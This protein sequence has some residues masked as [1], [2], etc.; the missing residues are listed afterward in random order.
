MCTEES[1]ECPANQEVSNCFN[2]TG[3]DTDALPDGE[4]VGHNFPH[5]RGCNCFNLRTGKVGNVKDK[6]MLALTGSVMFVPPSHYLHVALPSHW[7]YG[8]H[9]S[10]HELMWLSPQDIHVSQRNIMLPPPF[11]HSVP[12]QSYVPVREYICTLIITKFITVA[13][14]FGTKSIPKLLSVFVH[15]KID[16]CV[17]WF[18]SFISR[19]YHR[20]GILFAVNGSSV[21]KCWFQYYHI[22]THMTHSA[23]V[24]TLATS[25]LALDLSLL[26]QGLK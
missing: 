6:G 12:S 18:T 21:V 17:C 4:K 22:Q 9:I 26:C 23:T 13:V 20:V 5:V 3:R 16:I 15:T 24:I 14:I 11:S 19:F 2:I 7:Q 10:P 25:R 1:W 8:R